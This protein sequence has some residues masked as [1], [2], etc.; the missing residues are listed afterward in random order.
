MKFSQWININQV[1]YFDNFKI[2][3]HLDDFNHFDDYNMS[4]DESWNNLL[5]GQQK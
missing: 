5:F 4:Q 2:S 1:A 3:T